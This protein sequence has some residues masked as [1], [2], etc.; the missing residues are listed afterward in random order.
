MNTAPESLPTNPANRSSVAI[1]WTN[2]RKPTPWTTPTTVN[3]C[4]TSSDRSIS[5]SVIWAAKGAQTSRYWAARRYRRFDGYSNQHT[6]RSHRSVCHGF[7]DK[8][9]RRR[10]R[11]A[12][13]G[14]RLAQPTSAQ[15]SSYVFYRPLS[16]LLDG[17]C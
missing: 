15:A 14:I 6:S 9:H 4:L 10:V 1:R 17:R 16:E 5:A 3:R 7:P 8:T 11:H 12:L 2:G 13:V